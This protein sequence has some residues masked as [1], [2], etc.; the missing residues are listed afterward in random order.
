MIKK[1][2]AALACMAMAFLSMAPPA[3][4]AEDPILAFDLATTVAPAPVQTVEMVQADRVANPVT[5]RHQRLSSGIGE[6]EILGAGLIVM[7]LV[8]ILAMGSS[9]SKQQRPDNYTWP[10]DAPPIF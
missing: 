3:L 5:A 6:T 4:A 10:G 8:A 9:K 7:T 1:V 2:F